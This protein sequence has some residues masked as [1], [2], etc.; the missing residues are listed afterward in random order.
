MDPKPDERKDDEKEYAKDDGM[1]LF[2]SLTKGG[3]V[4]SIVS[5]WVQQFELSQTN[6]MTELV[7]FLLR[8]SGSDVIVDS[9]QIEDPDSFTDSL[10]SL[11]EQMQQKEPTDYP[12]N[13]KRSKGNIKFKKNFLDFWS[14]LVLKLKSM[15]LLQETTCI[16]TLL[17][18][19]CT[20][21]SSAF[22]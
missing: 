12:L 1:F 2:E 3:A 14:K 9:Q 17:Q 10:E 13:V 22:R 19:L 6:A 18:W 5:D 11:Q 4:Q 15:D 7:N 20:M 21:S 8:S 16:Q